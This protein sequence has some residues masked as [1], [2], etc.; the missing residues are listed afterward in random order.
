MGSSSGIGVDDSRAACV[1]L[2]RGRRL[3]MGLSRVRTAKA[4]PWRSL[5]LAR[6]RLESYSTARWGQALDDPRVGSEAVK[7]ELA[8]SGYGS[9][10]VE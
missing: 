10:S 6:D 8:T 1:K 3:E 5:V 2:S 9:E 4:L 7:G